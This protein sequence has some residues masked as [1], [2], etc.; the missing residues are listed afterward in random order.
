MKIVNLSEQNSIINQYMAEMRD[1]DYQKNRFLFRNNIQRIGEFEAF[2]ISKTLDYE[3]TKVTTPLGEATVNLPTDK[4]VLATIFR[5]G[6]P[7]H[8]GFLNVFDHA[9]N[10]FVSAYREYTDA[11]HHNVGIHVEYLATPDIEGKTLIIADP[12][13]ATGGSMEM[14]YKAILTKGTPKCVHVACVIACPE[15][16]EH[17]RKTFPDAETTVWC[18]AIDERLNEHK[19][20]VPGFG[21]AGD[22][23][24]GGK[25]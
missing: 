24:Y 10:A 6:L 1:V 25:L 8:N 12:M 4:V 7:F 17:I 3:P 21:D 22:L 2:E 20:I 18:A 15:G 5:A 14:G 16:I 23:C 11:E 13:L 19:Y 9:G